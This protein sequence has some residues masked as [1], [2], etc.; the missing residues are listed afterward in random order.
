MSK[1]R[2]DKRM[3]AMVSNHLRYNFFPPMP[4]EFIEPAIEAVRNCQAGEP[5]KHVKIM[6][7][8]E[9]S[10]K[11]VEVVRLEDLAWQDR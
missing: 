8:T 7:Q 10:E 1:L 6:G 11:I 5:E 9:T 2:N 4:E 3:R